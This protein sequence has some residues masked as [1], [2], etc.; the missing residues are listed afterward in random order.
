MFMPPNAFV[1]G[2]SLAVG[3]GVLSCALPCVQV[4]R[5]EIVEQLRRT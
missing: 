1:I 3:L 2:A 5:L 4:W